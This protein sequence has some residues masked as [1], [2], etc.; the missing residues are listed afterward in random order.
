MENLEQN[1]SSSKPFYQVTELSSAEDLRTLIVG[2]VVK[3]KAAYQ[4]K[5]F[6]R[7]MAITKHAR[8]RGEIPGR[9][10]LAHR[11][12]PDRIYHISA[13]IEELKVANGVVELDGSKGESISIWGNDW[14]WYHFLMEELEKAGL[15]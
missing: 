5:I 6:E 10:S 13:S 8:G 12:G 2:D 11:I 7:D 9:L 15:E 4:G 14:I 3:V 1:V